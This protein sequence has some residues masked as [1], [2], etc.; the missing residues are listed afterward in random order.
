MSTLK[1]T[2][3][4][5]KGQLSFDL[6]ETIQ[7]KFC[8]FIHLQSLKSFPALSRLDVEKNKN[9]QTNSMRMHFVILVSQVFPNGSDAMISSW[10][11]LSSRKNTVVCHVSVLLLLI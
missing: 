2:R 1:T 11:G 7:G 6:R 9:K 10:D 4:S 5:L 8:P 3:K